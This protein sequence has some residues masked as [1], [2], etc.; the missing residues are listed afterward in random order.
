ESLNRFANE[1]HVLARL[2]HAHVGRVYDVELAGAYPYIAMELVRGE[3]LDQRLARAGP[4]RFGADC[5]SAGQAS[6]GLGGA[7]SQDT[8]HRDVK[9]ANLMLDATR[10]E[11]FVRVVDFGIALLSGAEVS[12]IEGAHQFGTAAF[13]SPEQV[14]GEALDARSDLYS[15]ASVLFEL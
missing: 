12:S 2:E 11:P 13:M 3:A 8:I 14:A 1:A 9:P 5:A 7:P 10:E 4:L 6:S 15:L